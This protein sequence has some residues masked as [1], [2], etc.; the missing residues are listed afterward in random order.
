MISSCEIIEAIDTLGLFG[1]SVCLHSSMRSMGRVEGGPS[2]I[3]DAFLDKGCTLVAPTFSY[4]FMVDPPLHLQV[5]RNA[6]DYIHSDCPFPN[7]PSYFD[8][9]DHEI[10][11]ES[12][13]VIPTAMLMRAGRARGF[14]PI[15]SFTALGPRAQQIICEQ[16]PKKPFAPLYALAQDDGFVLLL[17][18]GLAKLTMGHA[19]EELA[20]R[21][22]FIRWYRDQN[23]DV[24][25]AKLGG[26]STGFDAFEPVVK[27][28]RRETR[29]GKS[30]WQCFAAKDLLAT[31][32]AAI[33]DDP[34]ITHC[35]SS[36][37][38]HCHDA[39]LGGPREV[40]A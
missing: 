5:E 25:P 22:P 26:C 6:H 15:S 10:S 3:I 35:G 27:N 38:C 36:E 1:K 14:H 30:R 2:V 4:N 34:H 9:L 23:G 8:P 24:F 16:S 20:G 13:G 32:S 33:C 37:C 19:A 31:L 7:N 17:G 18:V 39:M 28:I 29:L 11:A 40:G 21:R 12:M